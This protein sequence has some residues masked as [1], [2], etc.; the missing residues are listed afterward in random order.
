MLRVGDHN[1][2]KIIKRTDFGIFLDGGKFGNILL[3]KR[4][5]T[6]AMTIG[7]ELD[8]FI[9]LDSDDCIIATT[10][11]PHAT[12]GECAFLE[13]K[14][15]NQVGAFLDWGLP[16]DLLVPYS[17]QHKPMEVGRSYVVC[18]YLDEY[19]GRITA[20]SRLNRHLEERASGLRA[21]Q[22]VD[23]IICGRSDMGYKAVVNNSHLGLIFRDDAF[24]TLLYGEKVKGFIKAIRADRKID[25]SLQQHARDSKEDLAEKILADLQKRGGVSFLTDKSE[26]DAIYK[27][28]NVSKGNYKNALSLLYKQRKILIEKD[29]ITLV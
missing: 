6:E 20:S 5:V 4:Y 1:R 21:Q 8:V 24:R 25:L 9:Y 15:V 12:V 23:L 2:L 3:P 27:A 11:T 13:V 16:K 10:L 26:P 29:K 18:I 17:E 19:T 28:F 14:E 22:A 7:D